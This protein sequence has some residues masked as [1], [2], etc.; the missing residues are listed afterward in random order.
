MFLITLETDKVIGTNNGYI[1]NT[2][3]K[4]A[5]RVKSKQARKWQEEWELCSSQ[6]KHL[7]KDFDL[8]SNFISIDIYWYNPKFYKKDKSLSKTCGD[9][10][11]CEKFIIDGIFKGIGLDDSCLKTKTITQ[12]PTANKLHSVSAVVEKRNLLDLNQIHNKF[13]SL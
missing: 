8:K 3:S 9:V 6:F 7:F 10:D 4:F 12:L 5:S 11:G 13:Q 2:R 1:I